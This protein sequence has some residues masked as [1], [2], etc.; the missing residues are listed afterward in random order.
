MPQGTDEAVASGCLLEDPWMRDSR[1]RAT[2]GADREGRNGEDFSC[3]VLCLRDSSSL[4]PPTLQTPAPC[5]A[6]PS[7]SSS[8]LG[9]SG[10]NHSAHNTNSSAPNVPTL[11]S[12]GP[13]ALPCPQVHGPVFLFHLSKSMY[14][15]LMTKSGEC[16]SNVFLLLP[17]KR[18]NSFNIGKEES[19]FPSFSSF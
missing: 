5:R 15:Y 3:C 18:L 9:L 19:E 13:E 17:F 14:I 2:P 12:D 1:E 11:T 10:S 7:G 4:A 8:L 6:N 16:S